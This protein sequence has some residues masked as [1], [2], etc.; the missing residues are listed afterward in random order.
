MRRE[1]QGHLLQDLRDPWEDAVAPRPA[2]SMGK[3][4]CCG[5]ARRS[6]VGERARC[7]GVGCV[8]GM[9]KEI[10]QG[11]LVNGERSQI[12]GTYPSSPTSFPA[13]LPL[14]CT[15]PLSW[16]RTLALT[17]VNPAPSSKPPPTPFPSDPTVSQHRPL[18][19]SRSGAGQG[20]HRVPMSHSACAS[21]C[22]DPQCG[23]CWGSDPCG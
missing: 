13:R 10:S 18:K 6:G 8:S 1:K 21:P 11:R 14:P 7:P 4:V 15:A 5:A 23:L 19:C 20:D 3:R 22:R 16:P 17:S 9:D 2:Q 12:R